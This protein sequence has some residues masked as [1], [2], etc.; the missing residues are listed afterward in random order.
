MYWKEK[1]GILWSTKMAVRHSQTLIKRL[2]VVNVAASVMPLL[3]FS[4]DGEIKIEAVEA[5]Y[6]DKKWIKMMQ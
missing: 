1:A 2:S 6:L 4:G 3:Y 5:A